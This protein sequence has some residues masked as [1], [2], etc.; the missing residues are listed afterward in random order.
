[1]NTHEL[2]NYVVFS[3]GGERRLSIGD[4]T[5]S[6]SESCCIQSDSPDDVR[7]FLRALATLVNPVQGTYRYNGKLLDFSDYR[8]LLP[9]KRKV[10]YI[11]SDTA[12]LSNRTIRENLLLMRYYRENSLTISLD[13]QAWTLCK[14]FKIEDK[15]DLRPA[16]LDP[17]ELRAAITIRELTKSPELL[18]LERPEWFVGYRRFNL[19]VQSVKEMIG[20][21]CSVVF[22]TSDDDFI[23]R[24]SSKTVIINNGRTAT[25]DVTST[26]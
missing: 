3:E 4:F 20:P 1:V 24:F 7:L 26:I 15:L 14:Q 22:F 2:K 10:G 9:L 21:A 8:R 5:L 11:A 25:T 18:L 16:D 19:F 17:A 13:E 23:D 6:E 12:M